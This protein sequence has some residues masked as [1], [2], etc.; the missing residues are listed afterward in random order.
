M[1]AFAICH[2]KRLP[3]QA[4]GS[5]LAEA[6]GALDEIQPFCSRGIWLVRSEATS[7]QI[8]DAIQARLPAGDGLM[9]ISLGIDASWHGLDA[10][11]SE[12]L[13]NNL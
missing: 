1:R 13:A 6:L 2:I 12:W 7:D 9:V 10:S 11:E 8:R 5:T 3:E 4:E